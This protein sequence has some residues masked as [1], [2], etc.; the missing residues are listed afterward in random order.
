MGIMIFL[1]GVVIFEETV[2]LLLVTDLLFFVIRS[3]FGWRSGFDM[4]NSF[5]KLYWTEATSSKIIC[6]LLDGSLV[7]VEEVFEF[8]RF[9]DL[10]E[11]FCGVEVFDY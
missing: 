5:C 1:K 11:V 4:S 7:C 6:Q 8:V 2:A 10:H 9:R 3:S